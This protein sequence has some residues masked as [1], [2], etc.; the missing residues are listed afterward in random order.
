MRIAILILAAG[1]F[2]GCILHSHRHPRHCEPVYV[3]HV[4]DDYCGHY[5]WRGRWYYVER[6]AHGPGCGHTWVQERWTYIDD[7][8]DRDY[9]IR[10]ADVARQHVCSGVCDHYCDDDGQ[11]IVVRGH[12]H[13]PECGHHMISG[14]WVVARAIVVDH[15]NRCHSGCDHYWHGGRWYR[16]H[17]HAHGH[18]CG[19]DWDGGR[20]VVR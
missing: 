9:Q 10:R 19:H 11:W 2:G 20:W 4:H 7:D 6:H 13:G 17:G 12:R 14:R 16:V 8:D 15:S 1:A 3:E 5:H 18:G